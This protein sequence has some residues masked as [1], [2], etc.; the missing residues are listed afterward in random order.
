MILEAE[1]GLGYNQNRG[2]RSLRYMSL[3]Y[4][5][6]KKL[7]KSNKNM[8]FDIAKNAEVNPVGWVKGT[9]TAKEV[10]FPLLVVLS[11]SL[12]LTGCESADPAK[13][14]SSKPLYRSDVKTIFVEM[15]QNQSFR[16]GFE[17]DLTRAICLQIELNTPYKVVSNRS[18][19]DTVL[20]GSINN[21][22][23]RT[24]TQQRDLDR[25][26]E[27]EVILTVDFT[28]KDL[29][30]GEIILSRKKEDHNALKVSGEYAVMS[31][32]GSASGTRQAMEEMA[33]R[34][35]QEMERSW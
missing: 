16:R 21:I 31:A 20:Y 11:V 12:V 4:L 3:R 33:V 24:L 9:I 25:P 18:Q 34:I 26:L 22:A 13:G 10:I 35:V 5:Q 29:R 15:F 7:G 30:N 32:A 17:F 27:N 14:Y 23:E 19:A 2:S 6:Q 1:R 8:K 28:W